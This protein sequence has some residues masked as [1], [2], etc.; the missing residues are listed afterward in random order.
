M[1]VW[2]D[3]IA[4]PE[5][6]NKMLD[7]VESSKS[8]E[9]PAI[10]LE[11]PVGIFFVCV[12][13]ATDLFDIAKFDIRKITEREGIDDF[14]GIQREVSP[15]RLKELKHYITT[16]DATFPTAIII[17][18][19]ERCCK[20][21]ETTKNSAIGTLTLSNYLDPTKNRNNDILYRDIAKIID[22]QHRIKAFE[23]GHNNDFN[24]NVAV[25]VGADIATQAEIF[26]TVNLAQ[27]KVNSSLVYDLFSLARSRSPEKTAHEITILLDRRQDSPFRGLIKRLGVATNGRFGETLSQ[28]TI[29]R[30]ILNHITN[31]VLV[32][33]EIGKR[34]KSWAFRPG[35][36]LR[37]IFR[38]NFVKNEDE[39]IFL[40]ILNYFK[41]ISDRWP[42]SWRNS[43]LGNILPRTNGYLAFMRFLRPV[44]LNH[45]T[46]PGIVPLEYFN[47]ILA[48]VDLAD[49][50][51]IS[52]TY[53]PGTGGESK[54]YNTLIEKSG[55][56][57]D[58]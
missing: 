27:T 53:P 48:T 49:E 55:L 50:S 57:L 24:L 34:Q 38:Y 46:K 31:N 16:T 19:D 42:N 44:I 35:D 37:Y 15:K 22:G 23:D 45:S 8:V 43:G 14:L 4:N 28:A 32:D 18:V 30:G 29:V 47:K 52:K 33:R 7:I 9:V 39:I 12:M 5:S 58:N 40:N 10:K 26:S 13:K 56:T 41:A 54:L 36:E 11:Q 20:F 21:S 3:L 25:F 51:F 1:Q 17:A 6:S 2:I